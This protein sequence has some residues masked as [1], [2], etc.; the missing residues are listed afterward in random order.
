MLSG[1]RVVLGVTG[2]IAC[3]K[4]LDLA[5]KLTQADA[6]VDT[7]MTHGA[8]A[9]RD[10]AG[11]PESDPQAS[12]DRRLR[13]R[14]RVRPSEHVGAGQAGRCHRC[15]PRHRSHHRQAGH[16]NGRRPTDHHRSGIQSSAD[17]SPGHGRRHVRAPGDAGES[18]NACGS[19]AQSSPGRVRA[20]WH[21]V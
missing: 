7:I 12:G 11:L 21:R 3:Y 5:S 18:S 20:A 19:A 14:F 8:D 13:C 10:P 16:G 9:V 6:L 2:S 15:C 17:G 4:A 1:K